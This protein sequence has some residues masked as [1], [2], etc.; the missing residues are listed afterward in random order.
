VADAADTCPATFGVIENGGCPKPPP[1]P[2]ADGIDAGCDDGLAE[3]ER[4][5]TA[6]A[7]TKRK[8]KKAKTKSARKKYSAK[9]SRLRGE[10]KTL[11][12]A[13]GEADCL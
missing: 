9:V 6:I 4:L 13:L 10:R 1:V 5:K 12:E 2:A 11:L 3:L 7:S 8:L